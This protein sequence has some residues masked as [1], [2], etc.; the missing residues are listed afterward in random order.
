[1]P[2]DGPAAAVVSSRARARSIC[3]RSVRI[4]CWF[5]CIRSCINPAR[6]LR[7][8]AAQ[9]FRPS[10]FP[11]VPT[12]RARSTRR[13]RK[14]SARTPTTRSANARRGTRA[15]ANSRVL[16][17]RSVAFCSDALLELPLARTL[18]AAG[19][20]VPLVATPKIYKK[21]HKRESALLEGVEILEAPDRFAVFARLSAQR[22]DLVVANL[23]IANGLEGMGFAVK[24]STELTF[25]ADPRILGVVGAVRP[26]RKRAASSRFARQTSRARRHDRQSDRTR[27]LPPGRSPRPGERRVKL[28]IW[29]YQS[30]AHVGV[31]KAASSFSGIHTILRAPKGDGYG[32]IMFAM[33]ER[34]GVAPPMTVCA[35]SEATLAGAPADIG[36]AITDVDRRL[37]PKMI[38]VTRSAT[39]SVLQEPLDG[40]IAMM[41]RGI[42]ARRRSFSRT[43]IRCATPRSARS[44]R[45][46][47]RS[48]TTTRSDRRTAHR[49]SPRSTSSVHRCW[50]FTISRTSNR[51]ADLRRSRRDRE[52]RDSAGR[53][54]RGTAHARGC[55][56]QCHDCARA[57]AAHA[58]AAARTI[59]DAVHRTRPVRRIGHDAMAERGRADP[60]DSAR[61]RPVC[62]TQRASC[63]VR[64]HRR[65]ARALG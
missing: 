20:A 13:S 54:A 12:A 27:L 53:V 40:E 31:T 26:F 64:A 15:N 16:R 52:L 7:A 33:F 24:W 17:G 42:G 21:F 37:A 29:S 46:S 14:R 48:S 51:C 18:R 19:V 47:R 25:H 41:P 63:V 22:P 9:R 6:G 56:A 34:L 30:P 3:R 45:R 58:A 8:N 49:A 59:R 35:L 1:M 32:A 60:R 57:G 62:C 65:R 11:M 61:S 50:A 10:S 43:R 2:R 28:A 38:V 36:R 39:A 4:P 55:V 5:R 23:N 44:P